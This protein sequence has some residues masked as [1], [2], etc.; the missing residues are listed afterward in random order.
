MASG[1]TLRKVGRVIAGVGL[2][3]FL[4][5]P[6]AY[7]AEPTDLALLVIS[8]PHIP[9]TVRVRAQRVAA[10]IYK[11]IGVRLVWVAQAQRDVPYRF[12]VKISPAALPSVSKAALGVAVGG[13]LAYAFYG[14]IQEFT[15]ANHIDLEVVLGHVIAHEIGHL[16]LPQG[17]HSKTGLMS[18]TW[19]REQAH[20]ASQR[21][22][23]FSADES[24]L[25]RTRLTADVTPI[26]SRTAS[27]Q[28]ER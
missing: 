14:R 11:E 17:S 25:I 28:A 26:A 4:N 16:L 2:I 18:S 7:A 12:V 20:G 9:E 21:D 24:R 13:T 10:R 1:S 22:L 23:K 15:D 6:T 19:T 8:N 3:G 27:L 5:A